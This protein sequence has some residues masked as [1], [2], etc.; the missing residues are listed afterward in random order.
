[1]CF[2]NQKKFILPYCFE[3]IAN[4]EFGAFDRGND[5][6]SQMIYKGKIMYFLDVMLPQLPKADKLRFSK[7]QFKWCEEN[8]QSIWAYLIDNEI[9]FSTDVK[10]FNSY[11]NY[12]PFAKGMTNKSPGRIAYWLGWKIVYEYTENNKNLTLEQ[13]MQNTDA[14]Q[15][16]QQSGY[17]P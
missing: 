13:L 12:S 15:I 9:L 6:L 5:F 8:E 10:R 7:K 1:M 2:T 3:A 14:Q 16:L 17:K 4:N 11:I